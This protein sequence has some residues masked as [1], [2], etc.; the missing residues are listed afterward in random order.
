MVVEEKKPARKGWGNG[1]GLVDKKNIGQVPTRDDN[2]IIG[3]D[4]SGSEIGGDRDE[5]PPANKDDPKV[6]Q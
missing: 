6:M 2:G 3:D 5:E 1:A 4:S